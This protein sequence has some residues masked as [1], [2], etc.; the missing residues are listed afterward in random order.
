MVFR[1]RRTLFLLTITPNTGESLL[2]RGR[3]PIG[4]E[5]DEAV[6]TDKIDTT[7]SSLAGQKKDK[8]L[9]FWIVELIH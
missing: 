7:P 4:I 6:G 5:E 8:L 1:A 9:A 3:I 2:I